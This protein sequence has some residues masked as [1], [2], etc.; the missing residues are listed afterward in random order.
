[1]SVIGAGPQPTLPLTELQLLPRDRYVRMEAD[2]V[3]YYRAP[4]IGRAYRGRL[5]RCLNLLPSGRRVLEI[6][7]GSGVSFLTLLKKFDRVYG[8]DVHGRAAV[9]HRSFGH[10]SDRLDL[11]RADVRDLPFE[12]G[13][14][15]A[16]LAVSIH[17]HLEPE[18]QPRAFAEVSRVLKGGGCYVIGV[19]GVN[20]LMTAAFYLLGWNIREH[21]LSTE[22]Q[23]LAAMASRFALGAAQYW[24]RWWPRRLTAYVSARGVKEN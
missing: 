24:P 23:V 12:D 4:V 5:L 7:Y 9:V 10:H 8:V 21:H 19:P 15:D 20:R 3:R 6:G 1:M 16:A 13:F 11:R 18:T 22:R 17:E 14:F 2:P